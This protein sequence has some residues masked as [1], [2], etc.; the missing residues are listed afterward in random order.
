MADIDKDK[1]YKP[2]QKNIDKLQEYIKDKEQHKTILSIIK[3]SV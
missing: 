3:D 2:K 1:M